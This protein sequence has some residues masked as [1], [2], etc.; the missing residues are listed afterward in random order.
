MEIE[1]IIP[2]WFYRH[3]EYWFHVVLISFYPVHLSVPTTYQVQ[4]LV[5]DQSE[6]CGWLRSALSWSSPSSVTALSSGL[7]QVTRTCTVKKM[8]MLS[9]DKVCDVDTI[10]FVEK[11][12]Y[13]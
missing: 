4:V 6:C 8:K 1:I 9:A 7:S 11:L 13:I 12:N 2:V 5:M 10:F 3:F